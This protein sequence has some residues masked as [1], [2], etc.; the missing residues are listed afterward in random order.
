[1]F[2]YAGIWYLVEQ[3]WLQ[4]GKGQSMHQLCAIYV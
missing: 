1:M 3:F 2:Q 4:Q